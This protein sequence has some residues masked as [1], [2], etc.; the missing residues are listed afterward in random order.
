MAH[1]P[2]KIL[3]VGDS[4]TMESACEHGGYPSHTIAYLNERDGSGWVELPGR[5]ALGGRTTWDLSNGIET[6]I[7]ARVEIPDYVF[8]YP[9]AND[10]FDYDIPEHY[11]FDAH[12]EANWK[13]AASHLIE[14]CHTAYPNAI[15]WFGKTYRCNSLGQPESWM[16][17]FLFPWIDD[18]VAAYPYLHAGI[19]GYEILQAGWPESM[20]GSGVHPA[21]YGNELLAAAI[22][23]EMFPAAATGSHKRQQMSG[24]MQALSG[25]L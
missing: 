10:A 22:R 3:F 16:P 13:V 25:G 1:P 2:G 18:M 9:G 6:A 23:D 20:G 7:A 14:A 12:V 24:G 5:Y 11:P 4:I 15:I 21:C 19:R 17:N 8:L